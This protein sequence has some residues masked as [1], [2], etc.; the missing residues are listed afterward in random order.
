MLAALIFSTLFLLRSIFT[1]VLTPPKEKNIFAFEMCAIALALLFPAIQYPFSLVEA[2]FWYTGALN[3]TFGYGVALLSCAW[4]IRLYCAEEREI[5]K[6]IPAALLGFCAGGSNYASALLNEEITLCALLM[7]LLS[8]KSPRRKAAFGVVTLASTIAFALNIFAPGNFKRMDY[9]DRSSTPLIAIVRSLSAAGREAL[10]FAN[11]RTLCIV[12]LLIPIF[13][14][15]VKRV[16]FSFRFPL[17]V[18]AFS[19]C[20]FAAQYAPSYFTV[21]GAGPG[22]LRN[23]VYF[24]YFWLLYGNVFYITGWAV[25]HFKLI[26]LS[27]KKTREV[28]AAVAL[29][30]IC[31]SAVAIKSSSSY[32]CAKDLVHGSARRYLAEY[33]ERLSIL[34][35]GA[36]NVTLNAFSVKP[37][38]LFW[39][40]VNGSLAQFYQKESVTIK[41]PEN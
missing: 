18:A 38:A 37:K 26:E 22:R 2:F 29:L 41:E 25:K 32:I 30:F 31:A 9:I 8:K 21:S 4:L 13:V 19:F 27:P 12:V 34:E 36:K 11:I 24:S 7:C 6:T 33:Y 40:D 15:I 20:V 39:A 28:L 1:K 3:Y 35:S 23:I 17:L 14:S 10:S 5:W 16:N